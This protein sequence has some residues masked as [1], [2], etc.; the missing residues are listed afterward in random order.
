MLDPKVGSETVLLP[1]DRTPFIHELAKVKP[2]DL[3]LKAGLVR[4]SHGP[5]FFLLFYVPDPRHPETPFS[6]IDAH[7]NAYDVRHMQMWRDLDVTFVD[8]VW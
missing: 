3:R 2:F 7:V 6:A 4:T 1:L 5:F 8:L